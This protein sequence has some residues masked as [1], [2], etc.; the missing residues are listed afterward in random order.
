MIIMAKFQATL[1]L[2][3]TIEFNSLFDTL[4]EAKEEIESMENEELHYLVERI[5]ANANKKNLTTII[6]NTIEKI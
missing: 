6:V 2:E 4:E 3:T 1:K 5:N